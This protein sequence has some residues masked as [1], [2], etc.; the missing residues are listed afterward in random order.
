MKSNCIMKL[1]KIPSVA[2]VMITLARTILLMQIKNDVHG[3]SKPIITA[4]K[5]LGDFPITFT[6]WDT[7]HSPDNN[8][9]MQSNVLDEYVHVNKTPIIAVSKP[10]MDSP[11]IFLMICNT[12]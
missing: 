2:R 12:L 10:S 6:I 4:C 9:I 11:I 8:K 7:R 3:N 5:I 1:Y